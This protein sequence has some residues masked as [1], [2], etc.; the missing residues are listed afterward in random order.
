MLENWPA[1]LPPR[2][3]YPPNCGTC[4]KWLPSLT[5]QLPPNTGECYA[6]PP[7][8]QMSVIPEDHSKGLLLSG[9]K[10]TAGR[11]KIIRIRTQMHKDNPGCFSHELAAV[12]G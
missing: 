2:E 5:Q 4:R 12:P 3:A 7:Q 10:E 9:G 1:H 11:F 8:T 6:L